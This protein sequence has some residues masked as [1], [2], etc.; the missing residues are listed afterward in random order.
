MGFVSEFSVEC[1]EVE[2]AC[3]L[4]HA[5]MCILSNTCI[6]IYLSIYL[7][8]Y[9][10]HMS[11]LEFVEARRLKLESQSPK[12]ISCVEVAVLLAREV[13]RFTW[14]ELKAA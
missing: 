9:N 14:L 13:H 12:P 7:A 3:I 8:N 2:H 4:V 11:H 6:P 5:D 1:W 10:I